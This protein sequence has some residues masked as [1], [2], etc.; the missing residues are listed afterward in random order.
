MRK[1][2]KLEKGKSEHQVVIKKN[3]CF[4][5]KHQELLKDALEHKHSKYVLHGGRGSL[6]SSCVSEVIPLIMMTDPRYNA[7]VFRKVGNTL[8]TSVFE[9]YIWAIEKLG[10]QDLWRVTTNPL[11]LTFI[12]TGQR[13]MFFGLDDPMKVKS[14]KVA[15]GYIAIIH[16]EEVDQFSGEAELRKVNQ[17]IKRGGDKFWEFRSFNPPISANNWAN[18]SLLENRASTYFCQTNYTD[19]PP[20]WLG[21]EFIAE[22]EYLKEINPKAYEH[23][24]L[25]IP[26]GTGGNVFDNVELMP[27]LDKEIKLFDRVYNG[28]DWGFYPDPT[29]FVKCYFNTANR[30]LYIYDEL[31]MIR[32][33]SMDIFNVLYATHKEY[34]EELKREIDVPD[35]IGM[36]EQLIADSASPMTIMDFKNY[37]ANIRGAVKGPDSVNYS[38]KW[39]QSLNKIYIDPDRCPNAAKEFIEYEYDRDRDGNVITGYP[40]A[41]NH[42]I[43]STRYALSR[44]WSKRGN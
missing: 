27:I 11:V 31:R 1:L 23:E 29:A 38:M 19:V 8:R 14:I 18:Q 22:A 12:P 41:D 10:M 44:F 40:D 6:K 3:D 15:N 37:G 42:F 2:N 34:D 39:L 43:D 5:K 28:I 33:G 9:Q 20:E 32:A 26:T 36:D 7:C 30:C 13:I 25:G 21:E 35:H 4:I 24:Y 17:S 16:Y